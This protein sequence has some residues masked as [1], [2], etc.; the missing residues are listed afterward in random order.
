MVNAAAQ[1]IPHFGI[2]PLFGA[3]Q[4][5]QNLVQFELQVSEKVVRMS[6]LASKILV[7]DHQLRERQRVP[8]KDDEE[9]KDNVK[10]TSNLGKHLDNRQ[11]VHL[12]NLHL[13]L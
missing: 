6:C 9:S 13:I 3:S 7:G 8:P 12:F 5:L 2:L 11:I 4:S 1:L 10:Q